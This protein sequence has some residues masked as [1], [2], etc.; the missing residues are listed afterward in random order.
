MKTYTVQPG[1]SL[2]LIAGQKYGDIT[3]WKVIAQ[4]NPQITDPNKIYPGQV[5]TL[6][7]INEAVDIQAEVVESSLMPS[8]FSFDIKKH[9]P[10]LLLIAAAGGG[11]YYAN[12]KK[13]IA[14]KRKK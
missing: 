5:I 10:W 6:P 1:D 11:L 14:P 7:N 3:L 9:W 8:G 2:S 13:K 12:K 4:A